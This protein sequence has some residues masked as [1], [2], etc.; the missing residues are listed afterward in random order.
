MTGLS[1]SRFQTTTPDF[2]SAPFDSY[3]ALADAPDVFWSEAEDAWIVHRHADVAA[4]LADRDFAVV[5]LA[6]LIG[7]LAARAG[8]DVADLVSVVSAILFLRNPPGHAKRRHFLA[9]VLNDRPMSARLTLADQICADL[10][11]AFDPSGKVDLVRDFA[12]WLPPLFIGRL[13]G[14]E[15]GL[16]RA[17]M[18]TVTE[19]TKV[20]DRGRSLRFYD[21]VNASVAKARAP[22]DAIIDDRRTSPRE[23]GISRIIALSD[24]RLNLDRTDLASHVLFLL[25]AGAE[26]TSA[27]IGNAFAAALDHADLRR[28]LVGNLGAI[29]GWI[30]ET[31]RYDGPVHQATRLAIVDRLVA[32]QH[33]RRGDRLVLLIGAAHRDPRRFER[34]ESFDPA[35]DG[36]GLL[37]FGAGLHFCIGADL[38]RMEARR[39]L[40]HLAPRIGDPLLSPPD[41]R[42]WAHRTLRRLESLPVQLGHDPRKENPCPK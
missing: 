4:L 27:L 21:R 37:G 26:T 12:D 13:L 34:P 7:G 38:A 19:V 5:E 22:L 39:A 2:L 32:G 30:E 35:R 40:I 16:V 17:L 15:D 14:L 23:D 41:R 24:D 42:Y 8:R 1:F 18:T 25:I 31:L 28:D 9:A 20:F 33:I 6:E 11:A 10:S 29:D 3:R 36:T